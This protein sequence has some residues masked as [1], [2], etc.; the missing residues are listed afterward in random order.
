MAKKILYGAEA[1]AALK[2]GIDQVADL[3]KITL[4]PRG[5]NVAL[6]K[7][8]GSPTITNDGVSIA[9]D[10]VLADKFESMGAEIVK[11][12]ASKTNDGAGDGTTTSIV[13]LQALIAEGTKH[14]TAGMSAMGLRA[15][16]EAAAAEGVEFLKKI[17][18]QVKTTQELRNIATI[19]AESEELGTLIA[20]TIEKV[21]K[22]G[23][24]TTEESQALGLEKEFVEGLQFDRGYLSPYLITDSQRMEAVY[25][26]VAILIA[27]KKVSNIQDMVSLLERVAEA[28]K[29]ELVI[30]T[31]EVDQGSLAAFIISLRLS[32][33]VLAN[34]APICSPT[35]LYLQAALLSPRAPA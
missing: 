3:A 16:I 26:D 13:L 30:I 18:K 12:V 27:D 11:E 24:I 28:G 32:R 15:G 23:L 8:Y 1:R 19:S 14:L 29:K 25:K 9:K 7:G 2:S 6:D 21:G 33:R 17:S 34:A 4:G 10:I 5:R 20:D 31:E 35:S 22:D